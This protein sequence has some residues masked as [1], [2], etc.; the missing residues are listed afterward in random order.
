MR[1]L[2][3]S[4]RFFF[5]RLFY[6]AGGLI[7]ALFVLSFFAPVLMQVALLATASITV[8]SLVDAGFIFARKHPVLA[9]RICAERFSNG[10]P[11][12]VTI[13]LENRLPYRITLIVI[14]EIP[15]Q[16]GQDTMERK[17]ILDG[18][19]STS[20]V[21]H[22]HPVERGEYGFGRI[23]I[24][25]HTPLNM[26]T[27]YL[28]IGEERTV[29]VYPSFMQ[30]RRYHLK[31][32][33]GQ[34]RETGAHA[35]RKIGH[36]L[37]FEQIKDYVT[38]DDS[39]TINWKATARRNSIMVNNFM[40]ERSQQVICLVDKGRTMKM[41]F[42]GMTLLDYA[43]NATLVLSNIVLLKQDKAGM[44]AFGK[45][46]DQFIPPD[47]KN[48]QISLLM[49]ALYRQKTDFMD[50]DFGA[51]YSAVRYRIKQ[52]SLLILFTNFESLYGM[53][54][55]LPYLQKIASHHAVLVV[56]F[57]NS[58]LAELQQMKAASVET[59]YLKVTANKFAA[60]KRLIVKE[61]QKNGIMALLTSPE[62]LTANAINK[63]LEIKSRQL[64]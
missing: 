59:V 17:I 5:S 25:L 48:T 49:E 10:D 62:K 27:R 40:D 56:L 63:Y 14:D 21:Y 6:I 8:M 37:E 3:Y 45:K 47:K 64:F 57:E 33:T 12:M 18:R 43:I 20:L 4:M 42:K 38:G 11:N 55:Q 50:S 31:A 32:V 52:R 36:S 34:L 22:L 7:I 61:L 16:F 53:E 30:M 2:F 44:I 39:R 51:L 60:E 54:R 26:V 9:E 35:L 1:Q 13:R 15:R 41:P 23:N 28:T 58:E 19:E 29:M 46:V 24:L